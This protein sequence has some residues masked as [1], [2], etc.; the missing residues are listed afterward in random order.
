MWATPNT[1]LFMLCVAGSRIL[2]KFLKKRS[3]LQ[4]DEED[5]QEDAALL[6]APDGSH[7]ILFFLFSVYDVTQRLHYNPSLKIQKYP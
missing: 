6:P 7:V 5:A 4:E 2:D 3:S 1:A